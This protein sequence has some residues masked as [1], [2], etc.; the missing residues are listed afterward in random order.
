MKN[1]K[2]LFV[3]VLA[4]LFLTGC[5]GE[6]K[7][8]AKVD[9]NKNMS[10]KERIAKKFGLT[11]FEL[12][13]GIGPIKE[14]LKLGPIDPAMV[15]KG[16]GLFETKC[17]SCHKLDER[18]TGPAQRDVI[19][20]RSPEYI[21]NMILN[22]EEMLNKHPEAK[23]MLAVYMTKMT[24]QNVTREEARDILE[25]FRSVDTKKENK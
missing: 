16:K 7:E 19:E 5:G 22:P 21:M 11:V 14:K 3:G 2:S 24:F 6:K 1:Y 20:R 12:D 10:K 9:S 13:N 17:A 4:V 8:S 15:E 25:Y 23:K 18:F